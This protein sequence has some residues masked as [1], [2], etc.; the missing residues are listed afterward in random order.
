MVA[1]AEFS[2]GPT[3]TESGGGEAST[4]RIA[5]LESRVQEL[6]AASAQIGSYAE[7]LRSTY[8]TLRRSLQHMTALQRVT[9]RLASSL[10][11]NDVIA[12]LLDSLHEFVEYESA[13]VYL[14]PHR[15][16]EVDAPTHLPWDT[17]GF[18]TPDEM[19]ASP[20]PSP[21][22]QSLNQAERDGPV[23]QALSAEAI[24]EVEAG[25][26][27]YI[28]AAPLIAGGQ[29]LGALELR[30]TARLTDETRQ[31][32]S[33][34]SAAVAGA[35]H[36]AMLY[37]DTQRLATTDTLTGLIN[38]RQFYANLLQEVERARRMVYPL[39]FLMLDL[40]HFKNVND[41][42]G[43]PVG[44]QVLRGVAE[45]LRG[46]LRRTDS[47]GRLGGEE[48]GAILPG[49]A[50]T[51]VVAVGEKLRLAVERM[52]G[53]MVGDA[54]VSE[55]LTISVGGVSL[56]GAEIDADRLVIC[57]DQALYAAKRGGRNQVWLWSKPLPTLGV[58]SGN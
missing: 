29:H 45:A 31:L 13:V 6:E 4:R 34:L 37:Q 1:S 8:S 38:D 7:D 22:Y 49:A 14:A 17:A 40:D 15:A 2:E 32:L 42:Y 12:I 9:S 16:L 27:L 39:G 11:P 44:N 46:R 51:E 18:R 53:P 20:T 43:H 56:V 35:L 26:G 41:T 54:D 52:S 19:P 10:D 50:T 33:L 30:G 24:M 36:N 5:E 58:I 3:P 23:I 25:S 21:P 28:V 57:A 47:L 55:S 48:F